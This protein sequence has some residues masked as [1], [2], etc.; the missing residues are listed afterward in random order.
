VKR[1]FMARGT[2]PVRRLGDYG[3]DILHSY[4]WNRLRD[5]ITYDGVVPATFWSMRFDE[6]DPWSADE[7]AILKDR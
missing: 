5:A 1:L 4:L 3:K 7:T 6:E 2:N